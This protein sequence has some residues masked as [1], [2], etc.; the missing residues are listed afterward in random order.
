MDELIP[1]LYLK[2]VSSGDMQPA[3]LMDVKNRK[4]TLIQSCFTLFIGCFYD[5]LLK[6][7]E[8]SYR[9]LGWWKREIHKINVNS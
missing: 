2:D 7:I 9:I 6:K 8:G 1:W 4:M 5:G 3:L